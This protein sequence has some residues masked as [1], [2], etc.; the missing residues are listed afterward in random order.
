LIWILAENC[1]GISDA[2]IVVVVAWRNGR[3]KSVIDR[4]L[5]SRNDH[6]RL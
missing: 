5:A 1:Y 3:C 2:L 6:I 4:R